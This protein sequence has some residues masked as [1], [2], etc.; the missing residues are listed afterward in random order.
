[1]TQL[2]NL[3]LQ[4]EPTNEDLDLIELAE[5]GKRAR[6]VKHATQ[7]GPHLPQVLLVSSEPVPDAVCIATMVTLCDCGRG[8]RYPGKHLLLRYGRKYTHTDRSIAAYGGV[9]RERIE[10]TDSVHHC[11]E[12][13]P[14]E[15]PCVHFD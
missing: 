11:E 13:W 2:A 10:K 1:M 6:E 12:C 15:V 3:A 9:P 7:S 8:Y 4:R 5:Q 14:R